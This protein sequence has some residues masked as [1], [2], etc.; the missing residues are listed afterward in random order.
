MRIFKFEPIYK[1]RVWGGCALQTKFHRKIKLNSKKIGESWEIVDREDAMSVVC[2]GKLKGKS[3][4]S[5]ILENPSDIMGP[6]W[7]KNKRFPILVKWLDCQERLSLQVHP[8]EKIAHK[9]KGEPKTENWYVVDA[10]KDAG[11]FVGLN[12]KINKSIFKKAIKVEKVEE[13]CHRIKS[14]S[15]DS[16]LVESG[17]LHAIDGGNLILEIQQNSDT[18][19]RV[20]DWG[21]VGIDQ[22]PRKLHV[23]KSL[24]CID[25][26]DIKPSTIK[27][28]GISETILA[29]CKHFRIR[30]LNIKKRKE[31]LLK[32]KNIDCLIVHVI[33]GAITI[34]CNQVFA[35]EQVI[36]P[37]SSKCS[38]KSIDNS[39]VLITDSFT[40]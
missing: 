7:K 32:L 14:A 1:Q 22:K 10:S 31:K 11:L 39:T 9:L 28:K 16:I 34:G 20:Y 29:D 3:L 15:G 21:R 26:D 33:S 37:F 12:K 18:T 40:K 27:S 13:I 25:F 8:P 19:Y 23:E 35:G 24:K 17:R 5:I 30:K 6:S 38:I 2:S 4:R 36:S